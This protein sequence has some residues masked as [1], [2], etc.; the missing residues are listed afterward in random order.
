MKLSDFAIGR[1][2]RDSLGVR[3]RCTDLGTRTISAIALDPALNRAW[4]R[5]PP[6]VVPERVFD[7]VAMR[8][9][10]R[11]F[12][13]AIQSAAEPSWHPG[14][15]AAAVRRFMTRRGAGRIG[16]AS[17]IER[18]LLRVDRYDRAGGEAWHPYGLGGGRLLR[19][20]TYGLFTGRWVTWPVE[21][22]LVLPVM[23]EARGRL[24]VRKRAVG[25]PSMATCRRSDD[26]SSCA[27]S[28]TATTLKSP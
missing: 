13:E 12:P 28:A 27:R 4:F 16:Q 24:L 14:F 20:H 21:A 23:T 22:F 25:N 3:Y 9:V 1:V 18:G 5:G 10:F 2:F 6:Y 19:V 15:P 7:E 26:S 8:R 17:P 11:S